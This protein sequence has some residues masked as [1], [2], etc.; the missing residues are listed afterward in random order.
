MAEAVERMG[1]AHAVVTCVARDDLA[2]GGAGAFAADHRGH[3]PP[4]AEH[5]RSRC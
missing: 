2:D 1:L 4:L 3:P 5:R